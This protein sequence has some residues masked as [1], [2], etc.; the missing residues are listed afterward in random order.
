MRRKFA[1]L[2]ENGVP[3][4]DCRRVHRCRAAARSLPSGAACGRPREV[5]GVTHPAPRRFSRAAVSTTTPY[6]SAGRRHRLGPRTHRFSGPPASIA[7]PYGVAGGPAT[8][9]FPPRPRSPS[10]SK[11]VSLGPRSVGPWIG[12]APPGVPFRCG[13]KSV[14]HRGRS[15]GHPK[16]RDTQEG[17]IGGIRAC[18]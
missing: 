9:C 12:E 7:T 16:P 14:Y 1:A 11:C 6:G 3:S 15:V 10:A 8:V 17:P 18:P 2:G 13:R 4:H 5:A